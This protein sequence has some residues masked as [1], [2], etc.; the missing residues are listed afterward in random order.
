M[1]EVGRNVQARAQHGR[2]GQLRRDQL[3]HAMVDQ[4]DQPELLAI[5]ITAAAGTTVPSARTMR[6][7]HS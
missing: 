2:G 4:A 6:I 3:D 7:R 5:G 1:I